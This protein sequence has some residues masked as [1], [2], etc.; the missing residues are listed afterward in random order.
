M[1]ITDTAEYL[2][3]YLTQPHVTAEDRMTHA[4]QF[5]SVELKDVTASI[6]NSQLAAI[7]AVQT[8]FANWQTVESL[9]PEEHK[10]LPHPTPVIPSQAATLVRYPTPTSKGGEEKK[11]AITSKGVIQKKSL[12][13]KKKPE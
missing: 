9:P 11:R 8:I 2:H 7:E 5:L 10:V 1:I 13:I 4:I 12:T 6:Y 3:E